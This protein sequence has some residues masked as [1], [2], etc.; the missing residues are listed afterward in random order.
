MLGSEIRSSSASVSKD[1]CE[2][3]C[4]SGKGFYLKNAESYKKKVTVNDRREEHS[5]T[6]KFAGLWC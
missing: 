2:I 4:Y 1:H 3:Q 5:K 6:V